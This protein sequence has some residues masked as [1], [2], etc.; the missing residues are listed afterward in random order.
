M[1]ASLH[2]GHWQ[3]KALRNG[4]I[5]LCLIGLLWLMGVPTAHATSFDRQNLRMKDFS[6][7][8]MRGDDYTRA[9]LA[10]ANLQGVNL[11][12]VRMFD[13]NLTLANLEAADLRG[14]TLDGARLIRANLKNAMLEGAYAFGADF[15]KAEITGADFTDVF[16][17]PK[18]NDL[19]CEV[20]SGTNPTTGRDTRETL[21]CP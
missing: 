8:D 4:V 6:G 18:S 17:D 10:E 7:Q 20:A 5:G 3:V 9:D 21:F 15:R 1:R 13:A 14:S 12:G 19:L 11:Q 16:L 2:P